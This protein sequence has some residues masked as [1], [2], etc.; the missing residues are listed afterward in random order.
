MKTPNGTRI[1]IGSVTMNHT[2]FPNINGNLGDLYFEQL[3]AAS[4]KMQQCAVAGTQA[5]GRR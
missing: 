3:G 2:N 4:V 5:R 1:Y